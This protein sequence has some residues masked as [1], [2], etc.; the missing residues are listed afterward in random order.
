[1]KKE[2]ADLRADVLKM[3]ADQSAV[4][5]RLAALET[6]RAEPRK[7]AAPSKPTDRPDLAVVRLAPDAEGAEPGAAPAG[8]S[9]EALVAAAEEALAKKT[10]DDVVPKLQAFR[11]AD[12]EHPLA[13]VVTYLLGECLFAKGDLA[14][15][16]A[17]YEA[18]A[19]LAYGTRTPDALSRLVEIHT[20]QGDR[21]R[22]DKVKESLL[23]TYP[24][25]EAASKWKRK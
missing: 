4:T 22:A 3:R 7:E 21:A 23:A 6:A 16:R 17:A 18:V 1:M 15:A 25:S 5:T 9:A 12:P 2:L 10:C 14:A 11:A 24:S 19:Q 20:K 8:T 13:D